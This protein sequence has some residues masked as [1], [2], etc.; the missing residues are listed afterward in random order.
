MRKSHLINITGPVD[1]VTCSCNLLHS[2]SCQIAERHDCSAQKPRLVSTSFAAAADL[3]DASFCDNSCSK[4]MLASLEKNDN[5]CIL[6]HY[7]K[8]VDVHCTMT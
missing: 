8:E 4:N 1:P 5:N 6:K 7:F 2:R 3:L